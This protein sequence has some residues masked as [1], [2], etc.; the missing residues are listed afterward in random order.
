M[1]NGRYK[2]ICFVMYLVILLIF[3]L[4]I[5]RLNV[6]ECNEQECIKDYIE[7]KVE[8]EYLN[9]Q[10]Y[11]IKTPIPKLSNVLLNLV[12][13]QEYKEDKERLEEEIYILEAQKDKM[14]NFVKNEPYK[15]R[16]KIYAIINPEIDKIDDLLSMYYADREY[17]ELWDRRF[18]EYPVATEVW[19]IMKEW[20]WNDAVCAGVIGNMMAEVG[21]Q[22]LNLNACIYGGGNTYYGLCMWSLKYYPDVADKDISQQME[23]LYNSIEGQFDYAG[24]C[25]Q[26]GFTLN[27]FVEM[28]DPGEAAIAFAKV[29][30]RPA[31]Q[32]VAHR[33]KNAWVAYNYFGGK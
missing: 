17:I 1:G 16:Q 10:K 6:T 29:Y 33:A 11:K 22:T 13:N 20:G 4:T 14:V 21:G 15:H 32:Y 19:L 8:Q 3:L 27:D 30:E 26:S 7:P 28:T 18:N 24:F 12:Y 2:K 25:Y 31:S 9:I 5:G 23:L